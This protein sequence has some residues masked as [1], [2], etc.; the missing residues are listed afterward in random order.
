[1][2]H[3][4]V[5]YEVRKGLG[6]EWVPKTHEAS[7]DDVDLETT[8]HDLKQMARTEVDQKFFKSEDYPLYGK[9]WHIE[10]VEEIKY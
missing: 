10:S 3:F 4:L 9:F 5:H 1:M 8:D 7:F 2:R 6:P